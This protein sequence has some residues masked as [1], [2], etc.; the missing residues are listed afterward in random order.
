MFVR[1]FLSAGD[2]VTL[3]PIGLL[4]RVQY[5][6]KGMIEKIYESV[7]DVDITSSTLSIVLDNDVV[8]RKIPI[9]NGTSWIEG[10]LFDKNYVPLDSGNLPDCTITTQLHRFIQS[11]E[12]Y[13]FHSINITSNA[14]QFKAVMSTRH[15]LVTNG[16]T[17]L[18]GLLVSAN[19][20]EESFIHMLTTLQDGIVT[21]PRICSYYVFHNGETTYYN[22]G[23]TQYVVKDVKT[24]VDA[25]GRIRGQLILDD[26]TIDLDYHDIVK[27]N[28]QPKS[29]VM[30]DEESEPMWFHALV[31]SKVIRQ[32]KIP[33]PICGQ[34]IIVN[35]DTVTQCADPHCNSR[36]FG[37]V[38]Q[39]LNTFGFQPI[40]FDVYKKLTAKV[41]LDFNVTDMLNWAPLKDKWP[42]KCSIS[43]VLRAIIP[44]AVIADADSSIID[45]I[46]N[47]CNNVNTTVEYYITHPDKL[48]SSDL[49]SGMHLNSLVIWLS[50][51]LN[52]KD[53]HELLHSD[54]IE[55]IQEE[56]KFEGAPIF[57]SDTIAITGKFLH[58]SYSDIVAI[59][60]SYSAKVVSE[61][62]SNLR[63]LVIGDVGEDI[64]GHLVKLCR[65][66]RVPVQSESEFFAM[67]EIDSDL[68]Q[69]L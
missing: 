27:F 57:R 2:Y 22:L 38:N 14:M 43:K 52:Q 23:F 67:Y 50:D 37:R 59:L 19:T 61:F 54:K 65:S 29:V 49:F 63:C 41:G 17:N 24:S 33:C 12:S 48:A 3:V 28:V 8:P 5:N 55:L 11:P 66:H 64:D 20:T 36:L 13:K 6:E 25:F 68:A 47:R 10:V 30:L 69:N 45:V 16:F 7:N 31:D 51:A 1:N 40:T 42:I 44:H 35:P 39:L 58:G 26:N 62:K 18:P 56:R 60:Q 53:I 34:P 4:I 32:V 15:W 21:Y 9:I 46:C